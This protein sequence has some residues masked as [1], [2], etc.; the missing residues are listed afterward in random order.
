MPCRVGSVL[1]PDLVIGK[2]GTKGFRVFVPDLFDP[3]TD[4]VLAIFERPFCASCLGLVLDEALQSV[5]ESQPL[6]ILAFYRSRIVGPRIEGA[7][8][9]GRH[10]TTLQ[11][12]LR[13][14]WS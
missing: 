3:A 9:V 5:T 13:L 10:E 7:F 1:C 14:A 8:R 6:P 11:A 2:G 12:F 4:D